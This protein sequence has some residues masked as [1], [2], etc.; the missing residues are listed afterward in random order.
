MDPRPP[1]G[2]N[3]YDTTRTAILLPRRDAA[4][5]LTAALDGHVAV[6]EPESVSPLRT[7]LLSLPDLSHDGGL[8]RHPRRC[9]DLHRRRDRRSERPSHHV[10][11]LT[12]LGALGPRSR[13][14]IRIDQIAAVADGSVLAAGGVDRDGPRRRVRC[15]PESASMVPLLPHWLLLVTCAIARDAGEVLVGSK[16]LDHALTYRSQARER[17]GRR[18]LCFWLGGLG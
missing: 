17:G 2:S 16:T 12:G 3:V 7:P 18:R 6:V 13:P 1:R 15:R 5:W 14:T 4:F 9:R 8:G 11:D 10:G